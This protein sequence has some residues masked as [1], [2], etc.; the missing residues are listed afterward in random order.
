MQ[1]QDISPTLKG[2][3]IVRKA[4]NIMTKD[5]FILQ[6]VIPKGHQLKKASKHVYLDN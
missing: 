1:L 4:S 5:Y 3:K 6:I 2:L